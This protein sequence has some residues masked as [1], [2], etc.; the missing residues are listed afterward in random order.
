MTN[1]NNKN[2]INAKTVLK[3]L[4]LLKSLFVQEASDLFFRHLQPD[5]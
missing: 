1:V 2:V 4:F 3:Y 5:L